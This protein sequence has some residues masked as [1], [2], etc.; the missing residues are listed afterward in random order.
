MFHVNCNYPLWLTVSL[1]LCLEHFLTLSVLIQSMLSCLVGTGLPLKSAPYS[2][3]VSSLSPA[4]LICL[5]SVHAWHDTENKQCESL[6]TS[7][8][9]SLAVGRHN[10]VRASTTGGD[11]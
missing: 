8:G 2:L 10:T 6:E 9:A 7:G 3:C 1:W 11:P 5:C 4:V